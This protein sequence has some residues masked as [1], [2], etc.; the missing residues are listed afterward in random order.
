[1]GSNP[2]DEIWKDIIG[3]EGLYVVSNYGKIKSLPRPTTGGG[4]LKQIRQ[5]SG[6]FRVTLSKNGKEKQYGVSRLIMAA[7]IGL[8]P[9]NMEC[10]HNDGNPEN[11][12]I[13]NLRYDTHKNNMSDMKLHGTFSTPPIHFGSN[14]TNSVLNQKCI[15]KIRQLLMNGTKVAEIAKMFGVHITTIYRIKSKELWSHVHG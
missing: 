5:D 9:T 4:F 13:S 12:H 11:N 10:C 8:C 14:N 7:F 15:I 2:V 1:M 3:Y 6:H